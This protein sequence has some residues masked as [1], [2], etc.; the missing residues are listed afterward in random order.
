MNAKLGRDAALVA[1]GAAAAG[2]I[3]IVCHGCDPLSL[4]NKR[5][6][7]DAI[8][9]PTAI[10]EDPNSARAGLPWTP[11]DSQSCLAQ[12]PSKDGVSWTLPGEGL[13]VGESFRLKVRGPVG[14]CLACEIV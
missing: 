7:G 12:S 8:A 3:A 11:L 14:I 6:E 5:G 2:A 13:T 1:A 10:C 4:G 9:R